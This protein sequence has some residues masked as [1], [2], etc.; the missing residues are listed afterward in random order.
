MSAEKEELTNKKSKK[1]SRIEEGRQKSLNIIYLAPRRSLYRQQNSN[2]NP[3][4]IRVEFLPT[5]PP[6]SNYFLSTLQFHNEKEKNNKNSIIKINQINKI[7]LYKK[8]LSNNLITRLTYF[9]YG[10]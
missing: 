9:K 4:Q 3:Y 5:R 10:E 8:K 2:P 7:N 6:L 1:V